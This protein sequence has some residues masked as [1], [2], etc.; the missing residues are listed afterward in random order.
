MPALNRTVFNEKHKDLGAVMVN[1]NGW[2]MPGHYPGGDLREHLCVRYHAGLFDDSHKGRFQITGSTALYFLQHVLTNNAELLSNGQS[3][4]TIIQTDS[5]FA[6][7]DALLFRLAKNRYLLCVN[8]VNREHAWNHLHR[9]ALNFRDLYIQDKTFD[10]AMLCLQ[11]PGA[12]RI[13]D[14][15]LKKVPALDKKKEHAE[16][17][18]MAGTRVALA[19]ST[20]P[21]LP[22]R[23]DLFM[24]REDALP[25]WDLLSDSGAEPVGLEAKESLRLESAMPL[26][27]HELGLDP[28]NSPI[29]IFASPFAPYM[30]SFSPKKGDFVGKDA[31]LEQFQTRQRIVAHD[32]SDITALPRMIYP[33]AVKG[34]KRADRGDEVCR[35]GKRIGVVTSCAMVPLQSGADP[36]IDLR[37]G[38]AGEKHPLALALLDAATLPGQGIQVRIRDRFKDAF[39]VPFGG[40][41]D[42]RLFSSAVLWDRTFSPDTRTTSQNS[43]AKPI[44]H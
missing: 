18:L 42:S 20:D 31:L 30:V 11:G 2:Q 34:Q 28:E 32:C 22:E 15:A 3:Q 37:T 4:Y 38:T 13:I 10:L 6:A 14:K 40:K 44:P 16:N 8:A 19:K 25:V 36:G 29:P 23:L 39:V 9:E 35:N 21:G 27:G 1:C 12:G 24:D 43:A 5:G 17:T 26:F 33:V 41:P 7:D